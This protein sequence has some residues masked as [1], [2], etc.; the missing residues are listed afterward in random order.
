MRGTARTA[1]SDARR[2]RRRRQQVLAP[3]LLIVGLL[4]MHGLA[5][6]HAGLAGVDRGMS[7][8]TTAPAHMAAVSAPPAGR[9]EAGTAAEPQGSVHSL[10][11]GNAGGGHDMAALCLAILGAAGLSA[12][13][14]ALARIVTGLPVGRGPAV[15][16]GARRDIPRPPPDLTRLCISRT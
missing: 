3:L 5:S 12:L 15:R 6:S 1:R 9:H 8:P 16:P 14:L 13:A 10:S 7:L 11:F 4:A 2:A